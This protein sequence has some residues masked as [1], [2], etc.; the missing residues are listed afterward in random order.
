MADLPAIAVTLGDPL[1]I[2]PEVVEQALADPRRREQARVI[3]LGECWEDRPRRP[4]R[5]A[6]TVSLAAIQ[7]GVRLALSGDVQALVTAPIC[8]ESILMA[9]CP[10]PGHTELLRELSGASRVAMAF[11]GFGFTVAL[12]TIH[13][14]LRSVPRLLTAAAIQDALELLHEHLQQDRGL[15]H[16]RIGICALNPHAGEGGHLGREEEETIAP[17]LARSHLPG[18]TVSGPQPADALFAAAAAGA[19]DGV[20]AMYH[21]QGLGPVKALARGRAVNITLGL[22]FVRT[23]PDHGTA[24]DIAG[25]GQA[26]STSFA[27]AFD[28]A[29]ELLNPRDV[30]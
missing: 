17:A 6:G 22:P 11:A 26:S 8:K 1:G 27:A 20:L 23:S 19:W 3:L 5:E 16:P 29:L 7:E 28:L 12:A 15:L 13:V 21:D 2:G 4:D 10:Y 14:P 25:T 30:P 24:F 9:G 18:A